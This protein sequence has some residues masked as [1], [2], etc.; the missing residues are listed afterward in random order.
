MKASETIANCEYKKVVHDKNIVIKMVDTLFDA[1]CRWKHILKWIWLWKE[2][3]FR[4]YSPEITNYDF[5]FQWIDMK[6]F[7]TVKK[8]ISSLHD[9]A[10]NFSL[11]FLSFNTSWCLFHWLVKLMRVCGGARPSID[12]AS[13]R[14]RC[15]GSG[16]LVLRGG[17]EC[18]LCD[19]QCCA[20]R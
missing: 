3:W 1:M 20:L 19:V 2:S 12:R 4:K 11:L 10:R 16:K 13:G 6:I 17:V 5:K 7:W 14:W 15:A 18:T 9:E 8:E